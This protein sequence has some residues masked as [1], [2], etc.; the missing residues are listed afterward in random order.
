MCLYIYAPWQSFA[1]LFHLSFKETPYRLF[2]I[3]L[4]V[5]FF[6]LATFY[7]DVHVYIQSMKI[8]IM[9]NDDDNND[10]HD[11]DA[12]DEGEDEETENKTTQKKKTKRKH[13]TR[14]RENHNNNNND[15]ADWVQKRNFERQ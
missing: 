12:E 13:T 15:N 14:K 7:D 11:A 3:R 4:A 6:F 2:N 10:N 9:N 8:A 5:G 1:L